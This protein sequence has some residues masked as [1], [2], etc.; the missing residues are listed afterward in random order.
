M[1]TAP[2]MVSPRYS[3]MARSSIPQKSPIKRLVGLPLLPSLPSP[4][5]ISKEPQK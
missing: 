5:Q 2:M 1:V 3:P 4:D